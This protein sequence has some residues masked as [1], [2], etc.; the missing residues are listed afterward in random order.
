[1]ALKQAKYYDKTDGETVVCRLCP[2]GCRLKPGQ[3]GICLARQNV[4]GELYSLNYGRV[5]A[6]ALDPIE[7]KPLKR[8]HPGSAILSAGSFGCNFKCSFCQNW[9]ISQSEQPGHDVTPGELVDAALK[10]V[11]AGNIGLAYTY[12]EP[13]I[14]YEFVYDCAVAAHEKGLKNVLVTNG[15][16]RTEPMEA[17]L[18]YVD[19][20]NIDLKSM[21]PGF[22]RRQ[23]K[24]ELG[25]VLDTIRLCAQNCHAE[26]TTLLIP[27]E[28]D[29]KEEVRALSE[30]VASVSPKLP[31]H[32]TRYHPDYRMETPQM[33]RERLFELA[34][35]A[36]E[37]LEYVYCGN[38]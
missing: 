34:D 31:L 5:T 23:C 8:F 13:S 37:R 28:N 32:L 21:D 17:L 1:M 4:N 15:Y 20:M 24:G 35:I 14:W 6:L 9:R 18:P 19:A 11:G 30:W 7:K 27:G 25:P 36:R 38:V 3:T 12:N 29:S 10:A 26:L 2:H 22:Y 33:E 16:I